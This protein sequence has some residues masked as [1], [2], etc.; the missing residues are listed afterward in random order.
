MLQQTSA[1]MPRHRGWLLVAL[2]ALIGVLPYRV[3]ATDHAAH[4]DAPA[5][6]SSAW[7]PPPPP[8]APPVPP[9]P[10]PPALPPPPPVPPSPSPAPNFGFH[11]SSVDVDISSG[12]KQGYALFDGTHLV[13]RG[14]PA[15]AATIEQL[16]KTGNPLLWI[17]RGTQTRFTQDQATIAR[18]RQIW[19]PLAELSHQ[20]I[21]LASRQRAVANQNADIAR[22]SASMARAQAE[23][24]RAQANLAVAQATHA[25]GVQQADAE[26]IR[27]GL[28]AQ[29]QAIEAQR[30]ALQA[31]QAALQTQAQQQQ[32]ALDAQQAAMDNQQAAL[33]RQ[34]Q[35]AAHKADSDMD[36]LI[37][38]TLTQSAMKPGK[39]T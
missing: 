26:N 12:A 39:K 9:V 1:A 4:I 34:L 21:G 23:L 24:A 33:D 22:Q 17:R 2:V 31:K 3:V 5:S 32:H 29:R 18:A 6:A 19:T 8:P 37:D 20:Q 13:V 27:Q 14:T 28:A 15:D 7:L 25:T 11:A 16:P 35:T 38:E 36:R 10:P 30:A